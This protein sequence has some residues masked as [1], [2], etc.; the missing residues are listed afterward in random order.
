VTLADGSPR[1]KFVFQV[2]VAR[3]DRPV[4]EALHAY[5]A[6]GS[7]RDVAPEREHWLWRTVYTVNSHRAHRAATIPFME[8]YLLPCAKRVQ[9]DRWRDALVEYERAHPNRYGAGPSTCAEPG[10]DRPVR[11]RGLCRSHYYRATGY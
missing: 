7:L 4:L 8:R 1:R 2:T 10:C 6:H 3:R 11:G 5:L 9:F